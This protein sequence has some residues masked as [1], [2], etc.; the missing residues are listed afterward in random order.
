AA[1]DPPLRCFEGAL[2]LAI[3]PRMKDAH[4]IRERGER[5][6]PQ[7]YARLL[8]RSGEWLRGHIRAGEA[9]IPAIHFTTDGDGLR[10]ALEGTAPSPRHTSNLGERQEPIIESRA[11]MLPYLRISEAVIAVEPWKQG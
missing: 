11:A 4:A 3:P 5:L 9:G 8:S 2:R 6:D 1:R 10:R 7:V